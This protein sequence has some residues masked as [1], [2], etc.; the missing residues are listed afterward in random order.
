[1]IRSFKDESTRGVFL[2]RRSRHL[3]QDIQQT[4]FRKLIMLDTAD[5]LDTLQVPRQTG[6]KVSQG[7]GRDWSIRINDRWRICFEWRGD[8]AFEVEKVGCH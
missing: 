6:W 3:P 1:M 5:A 8:D 4:A 7:T 2:R